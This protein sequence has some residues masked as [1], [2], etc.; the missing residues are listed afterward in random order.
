MGSNQ[1][2]AG[3]V[4]DMCVYY[5]TGTPKALPKV[6]QRKEGGKQAADRIRPSLK[7]TEPGSL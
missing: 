6:V 5:M 3:R 4:Y 1:Y 2:L 7:D